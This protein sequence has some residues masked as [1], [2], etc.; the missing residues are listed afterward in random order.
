MNNRDSFDQQKAC[1]RT[2]ASCGRHLAS[3][4]G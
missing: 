2:T 1:L 4:R 3:V